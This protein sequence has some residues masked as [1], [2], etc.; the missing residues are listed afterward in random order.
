M[1]I[2]K[3][4]GAF[5]RGPEASIVRYKRWGPACLRC[6]ATDLRIPEYAAEPF[7]S[8][9]RLPPQNLEPWGSAGAGGWGAPCRQHPPAGC[10]RHR[11]G[12][13]GSGVGVSA[14][15]KTEALRVLAL[16]LPRLA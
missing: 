6:R 15:R 13:P 8:G 11:L 5:G 7:C 12:D 2:L 3:S 1:T 14:A 4:N 10:A 9:F 16:V